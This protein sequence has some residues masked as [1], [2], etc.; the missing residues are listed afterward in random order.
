MHALWLILSEDGEHRPR[1]DDFTGRHGPGGGEEGAGATAWGRSRAPLGSHGVEPR[2]GRP[3]PQP[4]AE[5][6]ARGDPARDPGAVAR[7]V[8]GR[9]DG[10]RRHDVPLGP[11]LQ[12]DLEPGPR[13]SARRRPSGARPAAS[14]A[15]RGWR[16]C[17]TSPATCA[18]AAPRRRWARTPT[19]SACW[20][21]ASCAACRARSATCSR[22]SST[23]PGHSWSEG[24]RNHGPVHLGWRELNDVFLLPVRDGGE[25]GARRLGDA[26]LPRHRQRVVPRVAP[27]A[28]RGA[29]RASGAST[30]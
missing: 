25:A 30:G 1:Q 3:R 20:A 14:A 19:W 5:V 26:G 24:A 10:P 17:S 21:P 22:R 6:P 2:T 8:P 4:A 27:P 18:G 23:T 7:G 13:S 16:R 9:P 15:T 11:R 12:R 29:P 28:H